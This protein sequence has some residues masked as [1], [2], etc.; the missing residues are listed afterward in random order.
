MLGAVDVVVDGDAVEIS[1]RSQRTVLA[2]L[3]ARPGIV[4]PADVLVDAI[5]ADEPPPSAAGSLRT[6]V[7]R[8]RRIVGDAIVGVAGGY[9]LDVTPQQ[10]DV[11]ELEQLLDE[12]SRLPPARALRALDEA[13]ALWRGPPFGDVSDLEVV[14]AAAARLQERFASGLELRATMLHAVG[15]PAEA[16]AAAEELTNDEPLREAGWR[17]LIAALAADGRQADALRAFQRATAAL[18]EAGLEPSAAL[19][20]A[21]AAALDADTPA[22]RRIHRPLTVPLSSFVGRDQD[23]TRLAELLVDERLVTV[24]GPGGVG[25]TRLARTVGAD[26]GERFGAG[27]QLVELAGVDDPSRLADVL[28]GELG[29]TVGPE[30]A[31]TAL[32]HA[33]DADLLLIVD[34]CEHLVD[35]A[36]DVVALLLSGGTR[37]RILATSREP[38]AIDGEQLWPLDCLPSGGVAE[39]LFL[40]RARAVRPGLGSS[41][42]E[43]A[44]VTDIVQRLDGLPLALEMAAAALRVLPLRELAARVVAQ[45]AL[46]AA[47]RR[48]LDE[49]H[50]TLGALLAWSVQLLD[51]EERALLRS[52]A[53]FAGWVGAEDVARVTGHPD[54]LDTLSR[55]AERS[56]LSTDPEA[57]AARFRML[58]T[59]RSAAAQLDVPSPDLDRRHAEWIAEELTAADQR[60][61]GVDELDAHHRIEGLLDDVRTALSWSMQH[62]VALAIRISAR[63]FLFGQSRLRDELVAWSADLVDRHG[64]DLTGEDGALVLTAAA[65]RAVLHG[66]LAA[67]DHL[68][69]R[70]AA[71]TP[72]PNALALEVLSDVEMFLG[73]LQEARRTAS[74]ALEPAQRSGDM[75]GVVI[76][77]ANVVLTS[78]YTGDHAGAEAALEK[79][80]ADDLLAPSDR[81]WLRYLDGERLLDRDP[82]RALAALDEAVAIADTVGNRYLSALARVSSASLRARTGD[83]HAAGPAFARLLEHWRSIGDRTHLLTTLRNLVVLFERLDAPQAAAELLG[84]VLDDSLAPSYGDERR[85]LDDLQARLGAALGPGQLDQRIATGRERSVDEAARAALQWLTSPRSGPD[86]ASP[87]LP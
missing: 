30:G 75:H 54:P 20:S 83:P 1:S 4:V 53:V 87:G 78:A 72:I 19:R 52:M 12:A 14:R 57:D 47:R 48:D 43:A 10:L 81:A 69:R 31:R 56:L 39:Q 26:L 68:A 58:R 44:T 42:E 65:H 7:S 8:L 62:D 77:L 71:A 34:N 49:R 6:Y 32:R 74:A 9:R 85:M 86:R 5:W 36:A 37:L 25:K 2:V 16:V 40:D 55:L 23:R 45:G 24:V 76:C 50:R 13:V 3:A 60:L 11:L 46:P 27:V 15:R 79:A 66:D 59:V 80:P 84:S 73:R 18:A 82:D 41:P 61:R 22:P 38:L 17:V 21:E 51:D 63:S 67:A 29:L 28:A 33:G 64:D 70:A 35:A